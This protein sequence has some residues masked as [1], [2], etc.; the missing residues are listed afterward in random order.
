MANQE[1]VYSV[2]VGVPVLIAFITPILRLN[3]NIV[4]LNAT[5]ESQN[6][7]ITTQENRI[8]RHSE[9]I[10]DLK[11]DV[12]RHDTRLNVLESRACRYEESKKYKGE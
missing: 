1:F 5:I 8:N 9:E 2:V 3:G 12:A 10:D 6:K 7:D 4:K 11:I